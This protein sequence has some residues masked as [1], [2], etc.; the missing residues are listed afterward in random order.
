MKRFFGIVV[1]AL[2]LS[3]MVGCAAR[4]YGR[5]GPSSPPPPRRE[6]MVERHHARRVWV[7]GHYRWTGHR[8]VWVGGH[9]R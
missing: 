9:W 4:G 3:T 5:F 1:F 7:P 6:A 8:H 2:T